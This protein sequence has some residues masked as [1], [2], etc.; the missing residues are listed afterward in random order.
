VTREARSRAAA[1]GL[2]RNQLKGSRGSTH[3]SGAKCKQTGDAMVSLMLG[4]LAAIL[5]DWVLRG[6]SARKRHVPSEARLADQGHLGLMQSCRVVETVEDSLIEGPEYDL[7]QGACCTTESGDR[8]EDQQ[9]L[10]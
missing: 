2:V 6:R 7:E 9:R 4:S 8:Y 5:L 1:V 3:V 10:G